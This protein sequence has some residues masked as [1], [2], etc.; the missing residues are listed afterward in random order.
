M[1][2]NICNKYIQVGKLSCHYLIFYRIF[3]GNLVFCLKLVEQRYTG[4]DRFLP[5]NAEMKGYVRPNVT[6]WNLTFACLAWQK[7]TSGTTRLKISPCIK[8]YF[9]FLP[10]D[11]KVNKT[12]ILFPNCFH[13]MIYQL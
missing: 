4:S 9:K 6:P 2:N 5:V 8:T 12:S 11:S 10:H 3:N 1:Q 13:F 7:A